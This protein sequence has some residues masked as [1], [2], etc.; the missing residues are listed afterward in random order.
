MIGPEPHAALWVHPTAY[1]SADARL[2]ASSRG[3]RIWI[4]AHS[5]IY[6]FVVIRAVGG[7]G[8]I[9]IGEHCYIN[10]GATLYSGSGIRMGNYVLIGPG[11]VIAPANHA[12]ERTDIPI[13]H[14]G[15][16]PSRGGVVIDDDVW[17][18]AN[19]TLLDGARIGRGA[20]VAA[21]A[22][23][24]GPVEPFAIMGGIP[25]RKI[26]ERGPT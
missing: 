23:V 9:V 20:V 8:D 12:F 16:Q 1:V 10:P 6:D 14:Q 4:G 13:R 5:Q 18:G 7:D 24:N 26:G 3:T 22:V 17:V 19:C 15:F 25:A 2:H 21:G 11:C